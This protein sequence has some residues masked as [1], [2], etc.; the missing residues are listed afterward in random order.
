V[1]ELIDCP[2]TV[3][4]DPASYKTGTQVRD[5][6]TREFWYIEFDGHHVWGATARILRSLAL[7]LAESL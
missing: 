5:G 7:L 3:A 4:L 1:A 6:M 2:L